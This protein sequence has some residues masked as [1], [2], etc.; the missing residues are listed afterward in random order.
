[1]MAKRE[2]KAKKNGDEKA[3]EPSVGHNSKDATPELTEDQRIALTFLHKKAYTTALAV[4]KQADADLKSVARLAKAELGEDGLANI[5]D[6]IALES[7]EGEKKLK[8]QI[9]RQLRVAKWMN[10]PFGAQGALF[11]AV[12]RTPA[13]DK[14]YANGKRDG[15]AGEPQHNPHDPSTAQYKKYLEGWQDGQAVLAQGIRPPTPIEAAAKPD[16]GVAFDDLP[17][18]GAV[19]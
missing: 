13:V 12:D 1:M 4:K 3:Q 18:A 16:A 9:E 6:M 7:E 17:A 8:A 2:K 10:V 14:A 11:D 19:N 15:L 5:K